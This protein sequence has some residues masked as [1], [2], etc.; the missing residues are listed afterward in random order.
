MLKPDFEGA[1]NVVMPLLMSHSDQFAGWS[2][3]YPGF[4]ALDMDGGGVWMIGTANGTWG[5]DFYVVDDAYIGGEAPDLSVDSG[6][7][8]DCQDHALIADRLFRAM[9]EAV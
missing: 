9:T 6:I 2:F 4:I 3:E 1:A 5:A 8:A 7:L